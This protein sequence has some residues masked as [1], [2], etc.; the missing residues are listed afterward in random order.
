MSTPTQ[1][2]LDQLSPALQMGMKAAPYVNKFGQTINQLTNPT[3][4]AIV[5][6]P[7]VA[8]GASMLGGMINN[9]KY[10]S[11]LLN[12]PIVRGLA[13]QNPFTGMILGASDIA[14]GADKLPKLDTKKEKQPEQKPSYKPRREALEELYP[15]RYKDTETRKN[16]DNLI[17]KGRNF[18]SMAENIFKAMA[19]RNANTGVAASTLSAMNSMNPVSKYSSTNLPATDTNIFTNTEGSPDSFMNPGIAV[20]TGA[21]QPRET[22][23]NFSSA[24]ATQFERP[25]DMPSVATTP[26]VK[27]PVEY[28]NYMTNDPA[29]GAMDAAKMNDM[30]KG[31]IYASGQYFAEGDDGRALMVDKDL[32]KQVKRGVEGADELLASFI[33]AGG[34]KGGNAQENAI[35]S[36]AAAGNYLN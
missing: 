20:N 12:D 13:A 16:P 6:A 19:E 18:D 8:E 34:H 10:V 4:P 15:D 30:Q 17:Q 3:T 35:R 14:R 23:V 27:N 36:A 2:L 31:L 11:D 25:V 21:V 22:N 29:L 9:N 24:G 7:R 5:A 32:A 1:Y 28:T 26:G 33:A